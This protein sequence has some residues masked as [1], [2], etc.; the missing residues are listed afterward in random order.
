MEVK[1]KHFIKKRER[2][3]KDCPLHKKEY[4]REYY[5]K[6][7]EKILVKLRERRENE[8]MAN[9]SGIRTCRVDYLQYLVKEE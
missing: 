8:R 1:R 6:N 2:Y 5:R 3:E 7:K 4:A 9:T